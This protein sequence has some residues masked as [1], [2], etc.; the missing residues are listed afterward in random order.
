[1]S[2]S[3]ERRHH[4]RLPLQIPIHIR[5]SDEQGGN[6]DIQCVTEDVSTK[7]AYFLSNHPFKPGM[8]LDISLSIPYEMSHIIPPKILEAEASVVRV[9][10]PEGVRQNRRGVA[11]KFLKDLKLRTQDIED[12]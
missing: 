4:R 3:K 10:E 1:M 11:I 7:G 6:I 2:G 12:S 9:D 5:G 8:K